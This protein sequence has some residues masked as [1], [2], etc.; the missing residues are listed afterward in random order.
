MVEQAAQQAERQPV[1]CR[2]PWHDQAW[3]RL[4]QARADDRLPHALLITGIPGVGKAVLARH[5]AHVL[6]C[7]SPTDSGDPCGQCR[8]CQLA[9]VGHHPDIHWYRPE[10]GSKVIKVDAVRALTQSSVL[11][12]GGSGRSVYI[13]DPADGMNPAAANALLKTLEEPAGGAVLILISASPDRLPATI[14]SRCQLVALAAPDRESATAWLGEQGMTRPLAERLLGLYGGA[15]LAALAAADTDRLAELD[16]MWTSLER[17]AE[18]R[19]DPVALAASWESRD[20]AEL[21]DWLVLWTLDLLR[22]QAVPGSP[23]RF[24]PAAAERFQ[25]LANRLDCRN[26][27]GFLDSL[28]ELQRRLSSNL[29]GLLAM[30]RLLIDWT[31]LTGRTH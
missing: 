8:S 25:N 6:V 15:P 7:T 3:S 21:L 29:N 14:R 9:A 5:L 11:T 10:E 17:L 13:V 18:G 1:N 22:L 2:L 31:R 20:L 24:D 23:P 26:L 16:A 19:G 12:A 28:Y 30:E 27:H 4:L